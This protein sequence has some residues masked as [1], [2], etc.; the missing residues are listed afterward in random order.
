MTQKI[1]T[2][3]TFLS[4]FFLSIGLL[5]STSLTSMHHVFIVIP[6]IYLLIHFKKFPMTLSKSQWSLLALSLVMILSVIFNQDIAVTGYKAIL[7]VKYYIIGALASL[8]FAHFL[9]D[10]TNKSLSILMYALFISSTLATIS[11]IIAQY[12]GFNPLKWGPACHE[13]RNCGVF[14]MYMNYAHN[15]VL[16]D[17]ILA[18]LVFFRHKIS[19]LVNPKFTIAVWIINML[20]LFLSYTRGAW[21]GFL[22]GF[23]FYFYKKY[24]KAFA[25]SFVGIVAFFILA[26]TF[27]PS[28]R[29]TFLN[30][31]G[32]NE[33]RIGSFKASVMAAYER[34]FFGYGLL[35]YEPHSSEIKKRY[36]INNSYFKGHSHNNF[37]Q[38]LA[39]T[40]ILGLISFLAWIF[41]WIKEVYSRDDLISKITFPFILCFL[42]AGLTQSTFILAN[43]T[44][45]IMAVY[46]ISQINFQKLKT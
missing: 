36:N 33:E 16:L 35:N 24:K 29:D 26:F 21:I 9:K 30:R 38:I 6:L 4:L 34:P 12:S 31:Q 10:I 41:F 39:D 18:G 37:L 7:K 17:I 19:H 43:N 42:G 45:F 20:G 32:S 11:G 8:A 14:G 15:I 22:I 46:A 2:T 44:F 23:P 27:S 28:V 3:S 25:L 40:G 1:L 5:T 13:T